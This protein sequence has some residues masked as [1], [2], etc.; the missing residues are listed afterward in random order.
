M[1]GNDQNAIQHALNAAKQTAPNNE[2]QQQ[3]IES[4]SSEL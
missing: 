1:A 3:Q 4:L 2:Q